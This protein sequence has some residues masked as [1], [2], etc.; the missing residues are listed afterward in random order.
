MALKSGKKTRLRCGDV[1][2]RGGFDK[3][4]TGENVNRRHGS[5]CAQ[6]NGKLG[7]YRL[8]GSIDGVSVSFCSFECHDKYKD[9][10]G[11]EK[12]AE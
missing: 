10:K 2:K 3:Q 12:N 6:C 8:D 4:I 5:N 7:K 9:E 11:N 1:A